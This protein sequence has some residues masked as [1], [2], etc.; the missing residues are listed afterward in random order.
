VTLEELVI[1]VERHR[2]QMATLMAGLAGVIEHTPAESWSD[3]SRTA[4]ASSIAC[5]T[6]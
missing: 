2:P 3:C 1:A 4:T 6:G 5:V